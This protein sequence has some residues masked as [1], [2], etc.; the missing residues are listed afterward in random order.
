MKPC[1]ICNKLVDTDNCFGHVSDDEVYCD[2]H[3]DLG[4]IA[5]DYMETMKKIKELRIKALELQN[6]YN[7]KRAFS[8]GKV[9]NYVRKDVYFVGWKT[10]IEQINKK[11]KQPAI[12][13]ITVTAPQIPQNDFECLFFDL[14]C[15][16]NIE[17]I[18]HARLK[19]IDAEKF[20]KSE[21]VV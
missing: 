3:F 2:E 4:R 15:N 5:K 12:T 20:C 16:R 13:K 17:V 7:E 21:K 19:K 8:L 14:A 1:V 6:Q 11:G 9:F 10:K 18:V